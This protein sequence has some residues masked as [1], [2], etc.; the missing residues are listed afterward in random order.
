MP[1]TLTQQLRIND[2]LIPVKNLDKIFWPPEGLTKGDVMEYYI[3][4]WPY[5]A[6]HLKDRPFSG[7]LPGRNQRPVF[8]PER[9]SLPHPGS[10]RCPH[11]RRINYV[12][13][14]NLETLIWAVNL[15]CIEVHPWLLHPSPFGKSHLPNF[16]LDP[17]EP[18]TFR[19]GV[20][21]AF[22]LKTLTDHS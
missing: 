4:I 15:G 12:M 20:E 3:N 5:L 6:P 21:V 22:A 8:L 16:D 1:A 10:R 2:H 13:A 18:A 11:E 17:M 9:T 14:N 19:E 7:A